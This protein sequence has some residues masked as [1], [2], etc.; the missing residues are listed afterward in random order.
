M[1]SSERTGSGGNAR[2][3]RFHIP[4]AATKKSKSGRELMAA[5]QL[6][7]DG[8]ISGHP[9]QSPVLPDLGQRNWIA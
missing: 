2:Q 7:R 1:K 3:E 6:K 4:G 5:T 9:T 8:Q